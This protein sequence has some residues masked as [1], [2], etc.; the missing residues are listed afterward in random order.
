MIKHIYLNKK[1]SKIYN[2]IL[3]IHLYINYRLKNTIFILT[4]FFKILI[5]IKF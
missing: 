4:K 3:A 5:F 2:N 1:I